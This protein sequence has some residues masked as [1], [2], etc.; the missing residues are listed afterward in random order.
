MGA[1]TRIEQYKYVVL[2]DEVLRCLYLQ[3]MSY[4][5]YKGRYNE[6]YGWE[7]HVALPCP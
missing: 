2:V 4:L 1:Y 7:L 3:C 5:H 6:E